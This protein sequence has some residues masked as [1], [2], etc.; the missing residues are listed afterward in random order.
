MQQE[1]VKLNETEFRSA[2]EL[3]HEEWIK[4]GG[5]KIFSS[6]SEIAFYKTHYWDLVK[7]AILNRDASLCFRCGGGANQVHHLHYDF[8]GEDHL[9]P[10]S[11][12]AVCR[13]CH[14]LVEYARIA[15]ELVSKIELKIVSSSSDT[16]H[17]YAL[18]LKY[19]D[20]LKRLRDGFSSGVPFERGHL[21]LKRGNELK[22]DTHGKDN[23]FLDTATQEITRWDE[24][25]F[26][27]QHQL[28]SRLREEI[29]NYYLFINEVLRPTNDGGE[30]RFQFGPDQKIWEHRIKKSQAIFS[31]LKLVDN[32]HCP[33]CCGKIFESPETFACENSIKALP[34]CEFKIHKE[35]SGQKIE[36]AHVAKLLTERKTDLLNF[37]SRKTGRRFDA[38]LVFGMG[39]KIEFEFPPSEAMKRA[40]LGRKNEGKSASSNFVCQE[41]LGVCPVCGGKVFETEDSYLCAKSQ[42]DTK[43]CRFKINKT[44]LEQP[45]EPAQA[46]KILSTGKS[47]LLDKFISKAGKP[48]P[49]FLVMDKKGKVTFEF[50]ER[51]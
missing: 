29:Q 3:A 49:A 46:Q 26:E 48:F 23:V 7:R 1:L 31:E 16:I 18:L 51:D 37:T 10:E 27:R 50:P 5:K 25:S 19:Q 36:L 47:D 9:H 12:V 42:V 43:P 15:I 20:K 13:P 40:V 32:C 14:G 34:S 35:M 28:F 30:I 22:L 33:N 41:T 2:L 11:L 38:F 44:I 45:I 21:R 6:F 4:H 17:A 24:E 39:G 8:R